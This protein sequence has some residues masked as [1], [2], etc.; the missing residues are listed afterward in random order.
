MSLFFSGFIIALAVQWKLALII[1]SIIPAI[2]IVVSVCIAVDAGHESQIT[3]IYSKAAV[4][5]Q[6]AISS[7]KTVHA[8]WAHE[9][10]VEKYQAYLDAARKIGKKKSPNYG[11]LFSTEWFFVLSG[12]ALAF[13]QG[14]RMYV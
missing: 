3:S 2:L 6:E 14:F 13:W 4:S 1:M 12:T 5:A 7:I 9:K 10:M 8:F 11:I